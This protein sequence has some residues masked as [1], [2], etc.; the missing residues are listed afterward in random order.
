MMRDKQAREISP[1]LCEKATLRKVKL[2][3][4]LIQLSCFNIKIKIIYF[5]F[6]F[7]TEI[8]VVSKP[9]TYFAKLQIIVELLFIW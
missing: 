5:F 6:Y 2:E 9:Q 4:S 1:T 8:S 3:S 7:S